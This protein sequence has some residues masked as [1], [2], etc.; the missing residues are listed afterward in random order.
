[1]KE[2]TTT[3]FVGN[4]KIALKESVHEDA[5][6]TVVSLLQILLLTVYV[7]MREKLENIYG[8]I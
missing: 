2:S 3:S 8:I 5:T 6:Q 4:H 7:T 1:M